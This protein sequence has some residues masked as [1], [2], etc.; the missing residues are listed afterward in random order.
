MLISQQRRA[1]LYSHLLGLGRLGLFCLDD[2][3]PAIG[4]FSDTQKV[5]CS[6]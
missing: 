6:G 3:P 1:K 5:H 2:S 4:I